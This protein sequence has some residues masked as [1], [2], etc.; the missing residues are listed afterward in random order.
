MGV[1]R[2]KRDPVQGKLVEP[3]LV[4]GT[5]RLVRIIISHVELQRCS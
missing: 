1:R 5:L 3:V 4:S 2:E